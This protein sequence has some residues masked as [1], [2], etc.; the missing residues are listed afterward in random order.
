M[1]A[2]QSGDLAEHPELPAPSRGQGAGCVAQRAACQPALGPSAKRPGCPR[3]LLQEGL[4]VCHPVATV[5]ARV[6]A[7]DRQ[8]TLFGPRSN[9]VGMDAQDAGRQG[10]ADGPLTERRR[11]VRG[12]LR[13]Q[14]LVGSL[15]ASLR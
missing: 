9:G 5:A 1:W 7:H 14:V 10:D 8:P 4:E 13:W 12:R 3:G 11:G 15:A 2:V 6:D